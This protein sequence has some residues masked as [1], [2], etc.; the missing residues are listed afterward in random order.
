MEI[1]RFV[2]FWLIGFV[3]SLFDICLASNHVKQL[4]AIKNA[5]NLKSSSRRPGIKE[6]FLYNDKNNQ[7]T[8]AEILQ[9]LPLI[10]K[11]NRVPNN[12]LPRTLDT[13][14]LKR[15]CKLLQNALGS[16][17][18][19]SPS[20]QEGGPS[21]LND[22]SPKPKPKPKP[23]LKPKPNPSLCF[24]PCGCGG[25][26]LMRPMIMYKIKYTPPKFKMKPLKSTTKCGNPH[27]GIC[28]G[29]KKR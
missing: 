5:H 17:K 10:G 6:V 22:K 15:V 7:Q 13:S 16:L 9:R 18:E 29:R 24:F 27:Y 21:K 8:D 25:C 12:G 26:C 3:L 20:T 28:L 4:R 23:K 1:N 2:I 19:L 14:K 11:S